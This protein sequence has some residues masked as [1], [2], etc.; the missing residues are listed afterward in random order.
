ME[1]R[2]KA[3]IVLACLA[4]LLAFG[5]PS[6]VAQEPNANNEG[7]PP[8]TMP[9]L[10]LARQLLAQLDVEMD[11]LLKF[12]SRITGKDQE[13]LELARVRAGRHL[14]KINDLQP[15]LLNLI[16][17]LEAAG[18]PVDS[19]KQAF[20]RVLV[21]EMDAYDRAL[22]WW[23]DGINDLRSMRSSTPPEDLDDLEDRID[24]ARG[25]L[26]RVLAGE[27]KILT[28]ADSV[29]L[30]TEEQWRSLDRILQ[31]RAETMIGR[32][33]IAVSERDKL[34]S[35]VR[36][37]ERARA[38]E[39]EIGTDRVRLQYATRRVAGIAQSLESTI[40]LLGKRGFDTAEYRKFVI[41]TT[42]EVTE[43]V[44]DPRVLIGLVRD[45]IKDAWQWIKD[46][47]P[48]FGV[49]VLI[50]L[51][52]VV[53]FRLGFRLGWWLLRLLGLARLTRLMADLV[54]RLLN[55]IGTIVGLFAGLWFL[56]VNPTTLLAG[57]GVLGVIIGL[58]LQD[59]LSNLAA[60]L[61]ILFTRPYDVDD[62]IESGGV[63]GT[64]RAMG[65]ANT[66]IRTFDGRRLL[67]PNRKIWGEVI[68]NRSA[69]SLRRVDI[70]VRVAYTEDLDR[71]IAI[72]RDL[73]AANERVL[74]RPEPEIF[75]SDL[76]DSWIEI[77]VRPWVPNKDW[78]PLLTELPRL[79]RLRFAEEGIEIPYP[80]RDISAPTD[81][82]R[83]PGGVTA[84][85]SE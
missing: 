85:P 37:A 13:E 76:A 57:V 70:T 67:I 23:S 7:A 3:P 75:V 69:E 59:S 53:S 43:D 58:A 55:P 4:V 10:T 63:Q 42:G 68:E 20:G 78:W 2:R 74:K 6:L 73:L 46:N 82:E 19:I 44:L 32:I 34:E 12:E 49:R 18:A 29:G 45:F 22:R 33:Q 38:P 48:T 9:E 56:G 5:T 65:L 83:P 26:D 71:A 8:D 39:S 50:V 61:F 24:D 15:K 11:S 64:V 79:V 35:K 31:E 60:G 14:Q 77:A 66:T 81:L 40:D 54:S 41:Q 47:A 28:M 72:V 84:K 80:R 30:A 21:I 17:K 36:T 27:A 51:A 1:G 62:I 52:F 16:P 25:G